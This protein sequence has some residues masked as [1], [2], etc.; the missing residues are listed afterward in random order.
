MFCDLNGF[1]GRGL[2]K[3]PSAWARVLNRRIE[4]VS[5]C[6]EDGESGEHGPLIG[7]PS[8]L[9]ES[10]ALASRLSCTRI[11]L[12]IAF[13]ASLSSKPAA[14]VNT[15]KVVWTALLTGCGKLVK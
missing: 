10:A 11:A 7:W 12:G 5:L 1:A 15:W 9:G 13:S 2:L 6:G 3:A 14:R 4:G 8:E